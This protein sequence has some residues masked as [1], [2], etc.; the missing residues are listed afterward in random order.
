MSVVKCRV[1]RQDKSLA[2]VI[3]AQAPLHYSDAADATLDRPSHVRAGSSMALVP[4]GIAIIQDDTNFVA[5]FDRVGN[6]V[7]AIALPAGV[8]GQRQFDDSR[9]NKNDKLDLE[10]CVT[11]DGENGLTLMAFGSGANS[12][13]ETIALVDDWESREP[14]A[15]LVHAPHFYDLLRSEE[16][17]AGSQLNIEGVVCV[18]EVLRFFGRGNGA[19]RANLLPTNATCDLALAALLEYLR[20]P[21]RTAPPLPQGIERYELGALAGQALSFTDA[22][23]SGDLV[24]YTA[25]A[26][27]SPDVILDGR[28]SGSAIG[29]IDATGRTRWATLVDRTGVSFPGKVEGMVVA[30]QERDRLF[31]VVDPDDHES[32]AVLCTVELRGDWINPTLTTD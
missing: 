25:A 14:R 12:R 1:A 13:R 24:F 3:I 22:S 9:G 23:L 18:G 7:R 10:A 27:D 17:F 5:V 4:G 30:N 20:A 28:V 31:V 26:E 6:R 19:P 11:V 8:S 32:A 16:R 15:T 2:A 21:E 29:V